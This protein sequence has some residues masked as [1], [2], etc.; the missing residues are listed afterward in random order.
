M[1]TGERGASADVHRTE[2]L[3]CMYLDYPHASL[4]IFD[5][6]KS[7]GLTEKEIELLK[8]TYWMYDLGLERSALGNDQEW[9]R[10][11]RKICFST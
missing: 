4:G 1:G 3:Y 2:E 11:T 10:R 7:Q 5:I 8:Q 9:T 6:T